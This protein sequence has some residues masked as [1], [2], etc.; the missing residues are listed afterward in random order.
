[1]ALRP[2]PKSTTPSSMRFI[3]SAGRA[4]ITRCDPAGVIV[5][6]CGCELGR[7]TPAT[8]RGGTYTP[9]FA[10]DET[11]VTICCG[12]TPTSYP[13]DIPMML[14]FDHMLAGLVMPR[15]SPG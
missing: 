13:R 9:P 3:S 11:M 14:M 4:E 12:E 6:V 5:M 15:V 1:M 2:V 8:M 10:T 7:V